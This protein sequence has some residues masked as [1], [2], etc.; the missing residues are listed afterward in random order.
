[1]E[2][3]SSNFDNEKQ[4]M[5]EKSILKIRE[6]LEQETDEEKRHSLEEALEDLENQAGNRKLTQED[7]DFKVEESLGHFQPTL[8]EHIEKNSVGV[9]KENKRMLDEKYDEIINEESVSKYFKIEQR[10]PSLKEEIEQLKMVIEKEINQGK[11]PQ[12]KL[13]KIIESLR[14]LE[15]E[16]E[17]GEAYLLE[18]KDNQNIV[19]AIKKIEEIEREIKNIDI[20]INKQ[21]QI[22]ESDHDKRTD[23]DITGSLN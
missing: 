4:R 7:L 18:N 16:L 20:E 17:D 13:S 9:L 6:E 11:S 12:E 19:D 8:D 23:F 21:I 15:K 3:L 5:L 1:M 14:L 2:R 10:I 22:A